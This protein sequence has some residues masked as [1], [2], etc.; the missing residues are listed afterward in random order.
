[1]KFHRHMKRIE[2]ALI[3]NQNFCR[4]NGDF[5]KNTTE[6]LQEMIRF[7]AAE[8]IQHPEVG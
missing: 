7:L 8:D 5:G 4:N 3:F 1:M 2:C 6:L